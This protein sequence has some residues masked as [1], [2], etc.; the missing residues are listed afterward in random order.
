MIC[1]CANEALTATILRP[2]LM[3]RASTCSWTQL[4]RRTRKPSGIRRRHERPT[5]NA[6][7]DGSAIRISE[8]YDRI[9][10]HLGGAGERH[11]RQR[12]RLRRRGVFAAE[13]PG[14]ARESSER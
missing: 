1:H 2:V 8:F 9:A 6:G 13:G 5:I 3:N 14:A 10:N 11:R 12:L 7:I 4:L